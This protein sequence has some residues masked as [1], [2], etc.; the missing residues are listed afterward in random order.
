MYEPVDQQIS[1]D[2]GQRGSRSLYAAA[3]GDEPQSKTASE[4]LLEALEPGKPVVLTTGFPVGPEATPETDG[5]LGTAVLAETLAALGAD[6][7]IVVD[8]RTRPV[9]DALL[10]V[11]DGSSQ[12][13]TLPAASDGTALLEP[14]PAAVLAVETPGRTAD[15]SYRNMT[16]ED[17]STQVSPRDALFEQ[18]AEAGILTVGIGDG[19]NEIGMGAI[20]GAVAD[21]ITHGETISCVTSVDELVVAG[22]SNWG[23]YGLVCGL[24]L[25][26]GQQLLH[27]GETERRLLAAA[28][29][30]GAIDGVTGEPTESVDG[31]PAAVHA[32]VVDILRYYASQNDDARPT[33][34]GYRNATNE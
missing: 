8:E 11:L 18:A 15:G 17:I 25:A 4:A 26:T 14:E 5:P 23:A 20:S 7:W 16:G 30:A 33:F 32:H 10:A 12:L 34:S 6:P 28:V 21:H 19:G 9:L 13:R 29:E 3:R 2:V 24:S 31:I 1:L 27:T 22:V